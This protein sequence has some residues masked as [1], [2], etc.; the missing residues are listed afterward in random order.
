MIVKNTD[1]DQA[2]TVYVIDDDASI[3]SSLKWLLESVQIRVEVFEAGH[4]FLEACSGDLSGCL[5]L[6]VRMPGMSGLQLMKR[7]H[8]TGIQ[9]PIIFLS[10]HGD[11]PMAVQALKDGAFDFLEK[12]CNNQGI[13]DCVQRALE[14]DTLRRTRLN[15]DSDLM[16]RLASLTAREEKVMELVIAGRSNKEI[17]RELNISFKTV[18]AHRGR[19]MTKMGVGSLV[20]LVRIMTTYYANQGNR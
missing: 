17:G 3:R 11:L 2:Q 5:V 1:L 18:E 20:D 9:T 7:L 12:P 19:L 14:K 13:L 16:K 15:V 6:D 8:H 10:A 4:A